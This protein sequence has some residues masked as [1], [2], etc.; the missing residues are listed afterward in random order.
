[1]DEF[2]L[3]FSSSPQSDTGT[4]KLLELPPDLCKLIE[5][6]VDELQRPRYASLRPRLIVG[7]TQVLT[8]DHSFTIKGTPEED[9]VLCTADKTYT[10]R[11]IVLS[12]SVLVVTPDPT[13]KD[14]EEDRDDDP[15]EE[16]FIRDQLNEIIELVPSVPRL[17][18][19]TSLLRGREYDEGHEDEDMASDDEDGQSVRTHSH[20]YCIYQ[21]DAVVAGSQQAIHLRRCT[22]H[23]PSE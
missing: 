12:N 2:E 15:A 21:A 11:S 7:P 16:V 4:F 1:M 17:H 18:K 13:S 19:L 5:S 10:I 20:S 23:D 22:E 14:A 9:A 6:S 3:R 8:M